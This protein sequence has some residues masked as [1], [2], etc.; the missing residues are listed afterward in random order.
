[1]GRREGKSGGEGPRVGRER[2]MVNM[3]CVRCRGKML[4]MQTRPMLNGLACVGGAE[5]QHA[6]GEHQHSGACVA[7]CGEA[8]L[9]CLCET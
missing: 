8:G 2:V 1:M 4:R 5:Q 6:C 3:M 7:T 9:V